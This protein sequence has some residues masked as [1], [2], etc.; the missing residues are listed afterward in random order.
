MRVATRG[1][2][3]RSGGRSRTA[4][5]R[6]A[7]ESV[8]MRTMAAAALALLL[9]TTAPARADFLELKEGRLTLK[10]V[11]YGQFDVRGFPGWDVAPDLRARSTDVRRARAGLDFAYGPLSGELVFDAADLLDTALGHDDEGPAFTPRQHLKDAYLEMAL[12]KS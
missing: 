11:G 5:P 3:S 12:G 4:I 2:S 8:K 1:S 10:A 7:T 6:L 9:A